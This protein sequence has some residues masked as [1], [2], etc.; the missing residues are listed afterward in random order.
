MLFVY[1]HSF[2]KMN[3]SILETT[4]MGTMFFVSFLISV[5]LK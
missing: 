2:Q 5:P 4:G 3:Y 1:Y